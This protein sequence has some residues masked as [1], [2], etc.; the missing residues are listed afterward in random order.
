M[1]Q[2]DAKIATILR[3]HGLSLTKQRL[4]V[5]ELLEGRD[6]VSMHEL[7]ELAQGGLDRASL[8]R[9]VSVFEQLGVVRRVHIGWKYKIELSD[10][11]AG[12]HHHLTCLACYKV[13]PIS[14]VEL[15]AF[16]G[17]AAASHNFEPTEHQVEI[18]GYCEDCK[19]P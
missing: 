14:E 6:P 1:S 4:I 13:I 15:E 2:S 9:T 11:F 7:Y 3:E 8:Y 17:S 16:I 19:H 12:H 5:F 18:Q 10:S